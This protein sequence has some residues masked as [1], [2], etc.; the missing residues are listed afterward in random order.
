MLFGKMGRLTSEEMILQLI[1][2]KCMPMLLYGLE[3]CI[4]LINVNRHWILL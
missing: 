4:L 2:S 3:A 1:V